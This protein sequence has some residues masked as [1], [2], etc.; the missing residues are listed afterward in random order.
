M[1]RSELGSGLL[2]NL[3]NQ[4]SY[5]TKY[6]RTDIVEKCFE[7]SKHNFVD[8][9]ITGN[10][11]T[12][13]FLKLKPSKSYQCNI[14]IVPNKRVIQSKQK[15]SS[16]IGFIFGDDSKDRVDFKKFDTMM[17]VV[18]SFLNY[19][20]LMKKNRMLID[21]I[22]I[23]EA[24]S[25]LIQSSFRYRLVGF[26]K[27]MTDTF[28]DK[29]IVSVTATPM[30]SQKVDIKLLNTKVEQRIIHISENQEKTLKRIKTD[31]EN[32]KK[33]IVALQDARLVRKLADK[34][35]V[36]KANIKVGN[37]LYQK[38]L[39]NVKL[40][41]DVESNLTIISSAGFEGFDVENGINNIYVFEDRAYDYQT[42]YMQN[43]IQVI[44]RSRK[45]TNYIEWCKMSNASRTQLMSKDQMIKKAESKKISFE[46]KMTD[47]NYT[48]IPKY[49]DVFKDD[50]LGLIQ[51]LELNHEKYD[52]EKEK[53]DSDIVG[54][55]IYDEFLKDR[56]FNLV[57][58]NEGTK[59]FKLKTPGHKKAFEN[60][61]LN[62]GVIR[63]FNLF[64]NVIIDLYEK[65]NLEGYIKAYEV[66]LRRKYW[67]EDK[68]RFTLSKK[69]WVLL[70]KD[71]KT[72]MIGYHTIKDLDSIEKKV[73]EITITSKAKKKKEL[74]RFSKEY[75]KWVTDF[76]KNIKDRYIRLMMAMSQTKVIF[77]KKIR[78]HRDF[79]LTTE[80]SFDLIKESCEFFKKDVVEVDIISC[81][82][83][84]IYAFCGLD[85]P[86]DFYGENKENKKEINQLINKLSK[87]HPL[88]YGVNVQK[89][90]WNRIQELR[91]FGFDKK[92]IDFLISEFWE[93]PKDALYNFCAYHEQE[94]CN[95][96]MR[97]L[98]NF[99][100]EV[101]VMDESFRSTFKNTRYSRRHD[102]ILIFESPIVMD[103]VINEFVYLGFNSWFTRNE[104]IVD[105][106]EEEKT[107]KIDQEID[108]IVF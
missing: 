7:P 59:R 14:I 42:F 46:K 33:V 67:N 26:A 96:L 93:R 72:E 38:I 77:P 35:N 11:F 23:D 81:N 80:V 16:K 30:L 57:Y 20:E 28:D 95:K 87:E 48:F 92:V 1:N 19:I 36:L 75:I 70:P 5:S 17:F 76:E 24:H 60:V 9:V 79:N 65:T 104:N 56:G 66:F 99:S 47:K 58:L 8:K 101:E 107:S 2:V 86:N 51:R 63:R 90:K 61:K 29:A 68:L 82:P 106:I 71:Q 12:T 15:T 34:N 74:S 100:E 32:K 50:H 102:S 3:M 25:F 22:L 88:Q 83:R 73:K 27:L 18:D 85:L 21:K 13:A 43:I 41:L 37:T 6:L 62:E 10:G 105:K 69:E 64:D 39:E 53:I 78:N 89:W 103:F 31:L 94:I 49:F 45:G 52:L 98:I 54:L 40:D 91:K 108:K 55:K 84:I 4:E 97:N 44:G